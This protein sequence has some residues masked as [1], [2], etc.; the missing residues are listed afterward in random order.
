MSMAPDGSTTVFCYTRGSGPDPA[1]ALL[2]TSSDGGVTFGPPHIAPADSYGLN[3]VITVGAADANTVFVATLS[4][5]VLR[6][7]R[8]ADAGATWTLVATA[9]ATVPDG[10]LPATLVTFPLDTQ[11]G[12]WLTGQAT[13]FVTH[14]AGQHWSTQ[15]PG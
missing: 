3:T 11:T 2:I 6:L 12:F 13:I 9:P 14:D 8:S 5:H 10:P 4:D 1:L 7:F 15:V